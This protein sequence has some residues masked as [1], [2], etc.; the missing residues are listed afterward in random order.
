MSTGNITR[1]SFTDFQGCSIASIVTLIA[2]IMERDSGYEARVTFVLDCM[3]KMATGNITAKMGVKLVE[4]VHFITNE[5]AA[6]IHREASASTNI[7]QDMQIS[8]ATSEYNQWAVWFAKESSQTEEQSL[9]SGRGID[10]DR[11]VVP[12]SETP[13]LQPEQSNDPNIS[14]WRSPNEPMSWSFD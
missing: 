7:T 9:L 2:G 6:K 8:A 14:S 1:F 13:L 11:N 4:A 12:F 5:A 3:R 10:G